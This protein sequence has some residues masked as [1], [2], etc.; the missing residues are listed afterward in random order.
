MEVGISSAEQ[1]RAAYAG[2]WRRFAAWLI[3][4]ILLGVVDTVLRLILGNA[5]TGIGFVVSAAYFTYFHGA[6]GQTPGDAALSIKIVDKGGPAD[7]IGYGRA[8]IRWLVSIA[9]GLVI[10]LG[11]LWM[12]WDRDKQTWHDKAANSIVLHEGGGGYY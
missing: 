9:S 4:A 7:V 11:Y 10:L 12:I 2:F 8:F 5:G 6:R 3:D 1:A